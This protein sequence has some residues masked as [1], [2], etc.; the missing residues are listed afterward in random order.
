MS[1]AITLMEASRYANE[2]LVDFL[3]PKVATVSTVAIHRITVFT[4]GLL[5]V[6][7][8]WT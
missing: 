3:M 1:S 5:G 8:L 4:N 6:H 2:N 7:M